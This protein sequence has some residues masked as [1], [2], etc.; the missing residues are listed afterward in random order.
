MGLADKLEQAP[1]PRK[2][3]CATKRLLDSLN[4]EERSAIEE[5]LSKIKLRVPGYT[6]PWLTG[7][8][9]SEGHSISSMSI[10]RHINKECGCAIN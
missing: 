3:P 2:R 7:I 9:V 4:G 10:Y 5:A 8:L 1:Q 6:G